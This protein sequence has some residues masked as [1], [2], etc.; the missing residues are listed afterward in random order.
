MIASKVGAARQGG[1]SGL[2]ASGE[3]R[4]AAFWTNREGHKPLCNFQYYTIS[5]CGNS[6]VSYKVKTRPLYLYLGSLVPKLLPVLSRLNK[7]SILGVLFLVMSALMSIEM[8][9]G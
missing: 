6:S 9:G 4:A 7:I 3:R 8:T 2:I 5:S 1:L